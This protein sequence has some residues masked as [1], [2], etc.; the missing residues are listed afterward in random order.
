MGGC[1][2]PQLAQTELVGVIDR[3]YNPTSNNDKGNALEELICAIFSNIP[4]IEIV[5][6]KGMDVFRSEEIDV[7]LWNNKQNGTDFLPNV[8]LIECK[9]WSRPM[10]SEE[11]SFFISKIRRK[12]QNFGIIV[13]ANGITGDQEQ[14][15]ASHSE[16]S[17]A[18]GQKIQVIVIKLNEIM[19]V[20]ST[21]Q[22]VFLIKKKMLQL[23]L[24]ESNL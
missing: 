20:Q 8:I 21:E 4:G 24:R 17:H 23:V 9:N 18:L 16:I 7:A 12:G 11:V 22:L 1:R 3:I 19:E 2:M 15:T 14:L 6:R 5:E 10:G 13:A